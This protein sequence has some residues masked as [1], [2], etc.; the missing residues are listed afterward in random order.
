MKALPKLSYVSVEPLG[1]DASVGPEDPLVESDPEQA[2]TLTTTM[3]TTQRANFMGSNLGRAGA[4]RNLAR[5]KL[6][7]RLR[8]RASR[9]GIPLSEGEQESGVTSR[10]W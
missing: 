5:P 6:G 2:A 9:W 3:G 7:A 4:T 1:Q 10:R 8:N